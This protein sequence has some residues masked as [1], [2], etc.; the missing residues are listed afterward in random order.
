MVGD[1]MEGKGYRPMR[2]FKFIVP[3]CSVREL[4]WFLPKLVNFSKI[5]DTYYL[6]SE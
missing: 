3:I 1:I 6:G 4:P 2:L 5:Y